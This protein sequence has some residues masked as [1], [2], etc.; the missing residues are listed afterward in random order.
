[1]KTKIAIL[2]QPL[3]N[4]YGGIIQNYALQKCLLDNG[5]QVETIN[6]VAKN[7]NP[8]LKILA[9]RYKELFSK[10][11]LCSKKPTYL[12]YKKLSVNNREFINK[13]IKLSPKI[14]STAEL[15]NYFKI[16]KFN[17]VLVGSDQVWR[18]KYSPNIYNFYLDFLP[19]SL[20][21]I[22]TSYAASF[23]TDEWEYT[24]EQTELCSNLVGKFDSV[25]V[26][27]DSGVK[28]CSTN[29]NRE[30]AVH[31]LD[32]TLLLEAEDYSELIG[33]PIENKGLFTYVLDE[34][35]EKL[36]FIREIADK[37][38]LSIHKN[39]ARSRPL[40]TQTYELEDYIIPP[41]E[42]WLQ[43]FRDA[44]FVITDSFHGTVFSIINRK[45]FYTI[46]NR[47]RGASR[48][49]SFLKQV[50]LEDRMIYDVNKVDVTYISRNIDYDK[51]IPI[52][53]LLK[54]KSREF[55]YS[56]IK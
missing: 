7:P 53:D 32:P 42:G 5:C 56:S 50:G 14:V 41:I 18:P 12:D 2:T 1:M 22:K 40:D 9:S 33:Q 6:R 15:V 17:V 21:L 11:I 39:Q 45:P 27:E 29:L 3:A 55:L 30:D 52:L 36:D 16:K 46:V 54:F 47:E 4:N 28:L 34:T 24:D 37:M 25:S 31:V 49:E 43:G 23:G 19:T 13:Y 20:N 48:F 35:K 44:E 8:K 51:V 38:D 10:Y 26:R